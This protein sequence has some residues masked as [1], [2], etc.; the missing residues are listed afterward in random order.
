MY[1]CIKYNYGYNNPDKMKECVDI[2][3]RLLIATITFVVPVIINLLSTFTAGENRRKELHKK[4]QD[5]ITKK[6]SESILNNPTTSRETITEIHKEYE[7]IDKK[8]KIELRKLNPL[9][10]FWFIFISLLLSVICL[11]TF[12]LIK[13]NTYELKE[14][15]ES[16]PFILLS[17]VMYIY[18]LVRIINILYTIIRTKRIIEND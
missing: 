7:Q 6:A 1:N 3:S 18:A 16:Q 11:L 10:Q 13:S 14:H 15:L 17:I 9:I 2:Y 5:E 4:D 12:Y 8:T